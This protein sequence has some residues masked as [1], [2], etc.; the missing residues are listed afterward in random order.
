MK[1]GD[2]ITVHFPSGGLPDLKAK[3]TRVVPTINPGTRTFAA[4]VQLDNA[5]GRLRA[6][7]FAEVRLG[8]PA[9]AAVAGAEAAPTAPKAATKKPGAGK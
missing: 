4:I 9:P 6:G 5:D 3:V 7:L 8:A 2:E 1:A